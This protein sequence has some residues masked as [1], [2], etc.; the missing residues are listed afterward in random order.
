MV[1]IPVLIILARIVDVTLDTIRGYW[2]VKNLVPG[3]TKG[4]MK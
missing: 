3:W 4:G 1:V 2:E